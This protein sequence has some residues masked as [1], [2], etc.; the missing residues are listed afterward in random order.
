MSILKIKNIDEL[1]DF[2]KIANYDNFELG[3]TTIPNALIMSFAFKIF[4]GIALTKFEAKKVRI[5][6]GSIIIDATIDMTGYIT[7]TKSGFF[8]YYI[9]TTGVNPLSEGI[10]YYYF[11]DGTNERKSELF[12]ITP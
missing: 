7:I 8:Y 4:N 5:I 11:S 1:F 10:Y 12:Q 6:N 2:E 3:I 9:G